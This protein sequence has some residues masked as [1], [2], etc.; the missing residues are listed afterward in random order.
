MGETGERCIGKV[1]VPS[2]QKPNIRCGVKVKKKKESSRGLATRKQ[3]SLK[4][5]FTTHAPGIQ[6]SYAFLSLECSTTLIKLL[7]VV[8]SFTWC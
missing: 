6:A 8:N 7:K 5:S 2:S 4:D 1:T 3:P